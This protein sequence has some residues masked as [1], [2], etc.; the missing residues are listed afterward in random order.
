MCGSPQPQVKYWY[1]GKEYE[2]VSEVLDRKE[3]LYS[4]RI[5]IEVKDPSQCGEI[6]HIEAT[7]GSRK[8]NGITTIFVRC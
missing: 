7:A 1:I 3:H 4:N 5:E 6:V 8:W 2:A